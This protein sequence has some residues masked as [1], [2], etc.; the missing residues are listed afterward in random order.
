M[1]ENSNLNFIKCP[2][3]NAKTK[4]AY[5]FNTTFANL[6]IY[7]QNCKQT[8]IMSLLNGILST[9]TSWTN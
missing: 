4:L 1:G 2:K 3:C 7:C 8:T 5:S 9:K 6:P